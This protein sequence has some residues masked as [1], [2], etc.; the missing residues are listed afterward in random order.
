MPPE[1]LAL[2]HRQRVHW[3]T[4]ACGCGMSAFGRPGGE[5]WS[6]YAFGYGMSAFGRPGD[7]HGPRRWRRCDG[8]CAAA[9]RHRA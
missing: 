2:A 1:T 7:A 4:F 6:T 8:R 5:G 3:S 9:S